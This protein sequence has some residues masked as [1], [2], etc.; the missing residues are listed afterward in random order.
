MTRIKCPSEDWDRYYEQF[1]ESVSPLADLDPCDV[2]AAVERA[3]KRAENEM[4][5]AM[6][7][8]E[9]PDGAELFGLAVVAE[10]E[11]LCALPTSQA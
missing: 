5:A 8:G 2:A 6:A 11:A 10:L 1:E 4:F 3:R 7:I 9:L